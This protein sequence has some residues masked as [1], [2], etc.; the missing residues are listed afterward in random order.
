MA[1]RPPVPAELERQVLVE[2]GHRC[3]IHTCRQVPV[4]IAHIVPWSRC[5]AHEFPNLIVL[6]PTCHT[7]FDGGQIDRR[8]MLAY[9]QA[10]WWRNGRYSDLERRLVEQFVAGPDADGWVFAGLRLLVS[11]LVADGLLT[12]TGESR[13]DGLHASL[14]EERYILSPAGRSLVGRLR[15][16]ESDSTQSGGGHG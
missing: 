4:E 5:R 16:E 10:A 3:A 9:K 8:S 11:R 6:C 14:R 15:G 13:P 12:A 1:K 2:A 7:R